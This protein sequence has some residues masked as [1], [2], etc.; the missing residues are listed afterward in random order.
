LIEKTVN[1][2]L[3]H[4]LW[5]GHLADSLDYTPMFELGI[6]ALFTLAAEEE[7]SSAPREMIYCHFPL[8]DGPENEED[9]LTMAIRTLADCL[10]KE[11]PTLVCCGAGM[12]RSPA[13]AAAA[14]SVH[15]HE[16]L[17]QCLEKMATSHHIDVSPGLWMQIKKV[18]PKL[19][20]GRKS[21]D[22]AG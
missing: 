2:I 21:H 11:I 19:S 5:I 20:S 9:I 7:N 14:L 16:P 15:L 12:S 22:A 18:T 3:P 6:K 8:V 10:E 13:I 1:Q 17:E 4:N